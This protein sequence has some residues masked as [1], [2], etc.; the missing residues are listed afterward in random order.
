MRVAILI[1]RLPALGLGGGT[2]VSTYNLARH[3]AKR[4]HEIHVITTL[5]DGLP[6]ESFEA[7]FYIHRRRV[8]A[9]PVLG[10]ISYFINAFR[11]TRSIAPDLVHAQTIALALDALLIKKLLKK[12]YLAWARGSDIYLPPRFYRRF[13][14]FALR[15]AS[16][17]VAQTEDEKELMQKI[18]YREIEVVPSGI[19]PERFNDNSRKQI[20]QQ[21]GIRDDEKVL[22]FAGTLRPVKGVSYLILAMKTVKKQAPGTRLL[23]VGRGEERQKLGQLAEQEGLVDS[24]IFAGEVPNEQI[25]GY[26]AAADIL[27]LPSLSEGF[28]MV[29]VEA[30]ASGL[31]I[32]ATSVTGVPEIIV[33]G[34]NGLLAEPKNDTE[35]A[36]KILELLRDDALRTRIARNNKARS[37]GYTWEKIAARLEEL[38]QKAIT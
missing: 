36:G 13:Y 26:M 37:A 8:I 32:V 25:P 18:H 2:E 10:F 22:L 24:V 17:L 31:P 33:D 5:E 4:G 23:L 38:Y 34:E 30:M 14:K 9:R 29:L 16:V 27:V 20:R 12:R 15:E 11:A 28:P 6:R 3:L 7:G 21:F 19:D 35:L 1:S